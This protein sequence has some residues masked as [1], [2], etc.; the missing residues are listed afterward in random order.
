MNEQHYLE[1][2]VRRFRKQKQVAERA[3][4]QVS[5]A[6][7][8]A[9]L[10]EGSNSLAILVKHMAGNIRSRWTDFLTSDGEKP[11]RR[12]DAEFLAEEGDTRATAMERWESSWPI[13]FDSLERLRPEDLLTVVR[14]RGEAHTV[15]E[16]ISRAL[17]HVAYHVGQIVMLAKHFA[18]DRWQ[19]L[20]V[21]RGKSAEYDAAMRRGSERRR[22][23]V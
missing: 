19:T 7:F 1:D 6:Q 23:G 15:V 13:L 17:T 2:V 22:D 3:L 14:I 11:D 8:S 5:D 10:D 9:T 16:A 4:A 12:R 18:G 20:S 21:A